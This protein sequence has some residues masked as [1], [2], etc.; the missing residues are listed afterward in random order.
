M[1]N[2]ALASQ[3]KRVIIVPIELIVIPLIFLIFLGWYLIFNV[4]PQDPSLQPTFNTETLQESTTTT[5]IKKIEK[6]VASLNFTT[7]ERRINNSY[8]I[9]NRYSVYVNDSLLKIVDPNQTKGLYNNSMEAVKKAFEIWEEETKLVSFDFVDSKENYTI[10]VEFTGEMPIAAMKEDFVSYFVGYTVQYGYE[11][12]NYRFIKGGKIFVSIKEYSQLLNIMVHEVGHILNLADSGNMDSIMYAWGGESSFS[13]SELRVKITKEIKDTLRMIIKPEYDC[14]EIYNCGRDFMGCSEAENLCNCKC[15]RKCL[16]G[17]NF[18]CIQ[19]GPVCEVDIS[20]SC[21][22][23]SVYC[24]GE[25]WES[26]SKDYTFYCYENKAV[27]KRVG[28]CPPNTIYCNG[29]C[30]EL[31]P[32][33]TVFYCFPGRIYCK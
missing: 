15:G 9:S 2:I 5:T 8:F 12:E 18:K 28:E 10:Y 7:P 24:N 22:P 27:C 1:R 20:W 21:S 33:G 19:E 3:K 29:K 26:C 14:W 30:Y 17:E 25:C 31:C 16:K 32:E 4:S 23:N 13:E 6:I 11:C